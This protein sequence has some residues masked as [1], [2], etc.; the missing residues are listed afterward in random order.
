MTAE[1]SASSW[2]AIGY[3]TGK[4]ASNHARLASTGFVRQAHFGGFFFSG[5]GM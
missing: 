3:Q 2:L 4:I 5:A 1:A